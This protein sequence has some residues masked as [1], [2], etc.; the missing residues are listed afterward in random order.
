M[1]NPFCDTQRKIQRLFKGKEDNV[2]QQIQSGLYA[3][4]N[5]VL[6][7]EDPYEPGK[8]HPRISSSKSHRYQELTETEQTAFDKLYAYFFYERHHDFWKTTALSRLRPLVATTE[9]LVCGEDL[10]MIPDSVHEVMEELHILS[11]EL[12]RISKVFG[13]EFTDLKTAQSSFFFASI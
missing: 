5:E 11:L 10:G 1:L 13:Q 4:A 6:F 2:S 12:G 9:M 8:Y 7:L 3:L